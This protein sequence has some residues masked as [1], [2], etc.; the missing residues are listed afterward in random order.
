MLY[1]G[2]WL[3]YVLSISFDI[4]FT[5][6]VVGGVSGRGVKIDGIGCPGGG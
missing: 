1:R 5:V 3:S 6:M 2:K 4:M